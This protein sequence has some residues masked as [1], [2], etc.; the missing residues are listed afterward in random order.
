MK[1]S[2]VPF[3]SF[4]F[5]SFLPPLF[6]SFF[7]R[8][9][10]A[11]AS[12]A[13]TPLRLTV[14]QRPAVPSL[15]VP[16]VPPFYPPQKPRLSPSFSLIDPEEPRIGAMAGNGQPM[17]LDSLDVS[18]LASRVGGVGNGADGRALSARWEPVSVCCG[19]PG[20]RAVTCAPA[21]FSLRLPSAFVCLLSSLA[22]PCA[23][24]APSRSPY[25]PR[26]SPCPGHGALGEL[27][28]RRR[29]QPHDC[30]CG[31]RDHRR[32]SDGH[33]RQPW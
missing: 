24:H 16:R 18:A 9:V 6:L 27:P 30:P 11:R 26:P 17:E 3:P 19:D 15:T 2:R 33:G 12:G 32:Q 13:P 21:P 31:R 4:F 22:R 7:M 28:Q 1:K 8:R 23:A 10:D 29:L 25:A 20:P 14:L 5:L